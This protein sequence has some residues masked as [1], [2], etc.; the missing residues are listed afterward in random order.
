MEMFVSLLICFHLL[1]FGSQEGG[2]QRA[3]HISRVD[4]LF[5][6]SLES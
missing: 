3:Q 5:G 6:L 1:F 4:G 2:M